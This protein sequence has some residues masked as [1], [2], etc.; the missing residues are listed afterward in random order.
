M[1]LTEKRAWCLLLATLGAY[2]W[3][4]ATILSG[5]DGRAVQETPYATTLLVSMGVSVAVN[6]GAETVLSMLNPRGARRK[7]ER[8][9]A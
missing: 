1:M 8:G 6:I 7:D 3:Y 9:P 5:V 4:V 2:T